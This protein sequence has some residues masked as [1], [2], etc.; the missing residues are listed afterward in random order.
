M[1]REKQSL[2]RRIEPKFKEILIE[3]NISAE[4]SPIVLEAIEEIL[5]GYFKPHKR[6]PDP[7]DMRPGELWLVWPEKKPKS[8]KKGKGSVF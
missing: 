5:K 8:K 2:I 4:E 3:E 7:E 6:I 1:I